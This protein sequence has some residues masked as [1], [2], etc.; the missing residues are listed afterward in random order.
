MP[1]A[2]VPVFNLT[3]LLTTLAAVLLAALLL[4]FEV[5]ASQ[6]VSRRAPGAIVLLLLAVT[7]LGCCLRESRALAMGSGVL[8]MLVLIA[9][10]LSSDSVRRQMARLCTAK[11]VWGCVL[12]AS[13]IASRYLAAHVLHSLDRQSSPRELDLED[14]PIRLTQA[15][16]DSDRPVS[17]FHF[18]MHSTAAEIERFIALHEMDLTQIIRLTEPN[19]AANCHG[20]VFTGGKYG[21][22]DPDIAQVLVD[23]G[24]VEAAMPHEGDLAIYISDTKITHSGIVRMADQRSPILVESKWGPFGVYLHG[25]DRQPFKGQCKFYRSE[26]SGH[27]LTLRSTAE[28]SAVA[29]DMTTNADLVR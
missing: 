11:V 26:R 24:Y 21:I 4:A 14:V 2:N 7:L 25:V 12:L 1:W 20:W 28:K 5:W 6:R 10:T 3:L 19:S 29:A 27:Q 17:L 9:G 23:N 18:K 15:I 22:R 13:M 8:A 16:T